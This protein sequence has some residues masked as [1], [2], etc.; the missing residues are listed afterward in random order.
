MRAVDIIRKKRDGLSL[1]PEEIG[2][3]VSGIAREE[4]PDYQVAALSMAIFFRDLDPGE[5]FHLTMAMARSG[6]ILD[7]S[8]VRGPVVDKHSTGGVGDKVSLVLGPLAASAGVT[9]AK[10][11]GRGLGHTGGT[12]DKLESIPGFSCQLDPETLIGQL[13]GIGVAI[14]S[15]TGALAPADRRMY[16]IRDVTA[17]V[18]NVSL[19]AAS[20]VS[21]KLAS[22]SRHIV[23]DVKTGRGAFMETLADARRLAEILVDLVGR[24]GGRA[25]AVISRMDQPLGREVGNACEVREAIRTLQGDG[26]EDLTALCL[27]LGARMLLL[28]GVTEGATEAE[29]ILRGHLADGSALERFRRMIAAQGG[30]PGVL[31]DPQRLGSPRYSRDL[32]ADR[33]GWVDRLDARQTG[34]AAA[35]LGA[36]RSRTEDHLDRT[37]GITLHRKVGDAVQ[38]GERLCTLWWSGDVPAGE[39]ETMMQEAYGIAAEPPRPQPVVVEIVE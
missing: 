39:A 12:V 8:R 2:Y 31:E 26:P 25:V 36:G 11:S 5:R 6:E 23:F 17:T 28:G 1:T 10:L 15:Q 33:S 29:Q 4:I 7:L 14:A 38:A 30:D 22:G 19:I 3:F 9:V 20:V 34:Q 37:A 27:V 35:L 32:A 21:K 18:E 16:A 13:N 24:A